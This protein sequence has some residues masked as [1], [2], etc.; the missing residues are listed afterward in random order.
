MGSSKKLIE[1][2]NLGCFIR[3]E[4]IKEDWYYIV[5]VLKGFKRCKKYPRIRA[6]Y[7]RRNTVI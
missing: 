4:A 6:F 5:C 2:V 3:R 7:K 1:K